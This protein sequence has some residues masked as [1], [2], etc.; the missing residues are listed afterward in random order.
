MFVCCCCGGGVSGCGLWC[1][2]SLVR[3]VCEDEEACITRDAQDKILFLINH[4]VNKNDFYDDTRRCAVRHEHEPH[5]GPRDAARGINPQ[6]PPAARPAAGSPTRDAG[7]ANPSTNPDPPTPP[8]P[9]PRPRRKLAAR[10]RLRNIPA[11]CPARATS[12]TLVMQP[13]PQA[14]AP[15]AAAPQA[16]APQAAA[17][18]RESAVPGGGGEGG[19]GD[20]GGGGGDGSGGGG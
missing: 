5:D 20:G 12:P 19:G 18:A 7:C 10:P 17:R 4:T 2:L 6:A 3:A 1:V 15:Q 14:A 8:S 11:P 13:E 16:A 9:T